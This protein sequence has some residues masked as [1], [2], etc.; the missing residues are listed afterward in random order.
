MSVA[1]MTWAWQQ[2]VTP[3]AKKLVL[4]ALSDYA[5]DDGEAWPTVKAGSDPTRG[6]AAKTGLSDR[7]V[8]GWIDELE[9]EGLLTKA[10]RRRRADGSLGPWVYQLNYRQPAA[11]GDTPPLDQRQP[12]VPPSGNPSPALAATDCRADPSIHPPVHP[13][14]G[15]DDEDEVN[16]PENERCEAIAQLLVRERMKGK[17]IGNPSA[18]G[19]KTYRTVMKDHAADIV[20]LT[21]AFPD[22]PDTLIAAAV[23]TG[24]TR[25]LAPYAPTAPV[26]ELVAPPP[27]WVRERRK[28]GA[29]S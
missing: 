9:A 24:D 3:A 18:Y 11:S 1:V 13:S 28:P 4:V 16:T 8:R 29:V 14:S 21:D 15:D 6:L 17:K 23:H 7:S 10:T 5:N 22:A 27:D 19:R 25:N 20:R 2:P 26:L 12:D